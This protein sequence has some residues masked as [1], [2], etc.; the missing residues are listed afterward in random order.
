VTK[1]DFK[2]SK[3]DLPLDDA[4]VGVT[5]VDDLSQRERRR[6]HD[7]VILEVVSKLSRRDQELIE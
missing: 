6:D 7:L 5:V 4:A 1:L 3:L 2:L